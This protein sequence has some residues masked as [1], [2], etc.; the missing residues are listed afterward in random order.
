[1][2]SLAARAASEGAVLGFGGLLSVTSTVNAI[3][4][5]RDKSQPKMNAA[6]FLTPPLDARTRMN[7]VSGIGSSVIAKPT[8]TRLRMIMC[9]PI[10]RRRGA[11]WISSSCSLLSQ[12]WS[13][14]SP[15]STGT[16]GARRGGAD[17]DVIGA[18]YVTSDQLKLAGSADRLTAAGGRQLAVTVLEVRLDGVDGDVHLAGDF[19]AAQQA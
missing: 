19:S 12:V 16:P 9:V 2:A 5:A 17:V 3:T 7:A 15:A 18:S 11:C 10:C 6:P 4:I 14:L 8:R 13:C 1:M